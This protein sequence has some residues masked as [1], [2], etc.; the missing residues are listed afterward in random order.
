MDSSFACNLCEL[1]GEPPKAQTLHNHSQMTAAERLLLQQ[2]TSGWTL[3]SLAADSRDLEIREC[4][5]TE[6][7]TWQDGHDQPIQ[8][9]RLLFSYRHSEAP[10]QFSEALV[11]SQIERAASAWSQC[12]IEA[13][14]I[15]IAQTKVGR[16]SITV[17]WDER[18]S[19]GNFALANLTNRTLSLSP[20]GFELLRSRN[21]QHDASQTL[22]MAISHEMG[23]FF[24]LMAHSRRCVDVMSYDHNGKGEVCYKRTPTANSANNANKV[25]EYRHLLPTACDIERCRRINGK[26]PLPGGRLPQSPSAE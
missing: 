5:T 14:V 22:Q 8:K 4:R 10:Q 11:V 23:H 18:E 3:S 21:P 16:D 6:L 25:V 12:D 7:L 20:K 2:G 19:R 9:D 26:S 17:Q 1:Q 24:G 15:P 13:R